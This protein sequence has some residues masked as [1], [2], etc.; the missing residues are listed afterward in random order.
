ML[1]LSGALLALAGCASQLEVHRQ[2]VD[3]YRIGRQE[4][5][6]AA[7]AKAQAPCV[8]VR[9]N[10]KNPV[11]PW[12]EEMTLARA[13]LDADD[14]SLTSPRKFFLTRGNRTIEITARQ[15]L[16]GYDIPL[17]AGDIVSIAH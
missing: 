2:V 11:I 4:E 5:A 8:S 15:L 17:E 13:I 3:A 7:A 12:T 9:G 10:V 14:Q 16:N 6:A 1:P